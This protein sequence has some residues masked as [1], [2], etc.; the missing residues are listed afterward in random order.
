[1]LVHLLLGA[2]SEV[3]IITPIPQTGRVRHREF[4]KVAGER[5]KPK[6]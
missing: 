1:M 6:V 2:V 3:G 5:K 4:K